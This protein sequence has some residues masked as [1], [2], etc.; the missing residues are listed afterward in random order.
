MGP[1]QS[2][3]KEVGAA[4]RER[5]LLEPKARLKESGLSNMKLQRERKEPEAL[6]DKNAEMVSLEPGSRRGTW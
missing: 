3:T 2:P 5:D 1:S 6:K 4:Q